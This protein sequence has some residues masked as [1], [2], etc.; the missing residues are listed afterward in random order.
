MKWWY[1][2][3]YKI[4]DY[5]YRNRDS[6]AIANAIVF[7]VMIPIANILSIYGFFLDVFKI[8]IIGDKYNIVFLLVVL[9]LLN[10]N[11]VYKGKKYE[12]IFEDM[13]AWDFK[14]DKP[15]KVFYI[16]LISSIVVLLF[17]V[18]Y[19]FFKHYK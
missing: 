3:N 7:S 17:S 18:A 13:E 11:L 16:Y 15:A 8:N 2:I 12:K 10:F 19:G 4:Y 14:E 1:F 5:Y 6:G 9:I